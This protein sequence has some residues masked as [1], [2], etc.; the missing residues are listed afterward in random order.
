MS[1]FD[2]SLVQVLRSEGG[3]SNLPQDPGGATNKGIIQREYDAYRSRNNQPTQTVRAITDDEVKAIYR[4]SYW[5]LAKCDALPVGV[6]YVVFDGAVNS[7][8]S[9]S[10][11]WLQRAL[12]VNV[13]GQIGPATISAA[14]SFGDPSALIDA[15]CDRRMAFMKAL[16]TYKYFGKGWSSRVVSVRTT[17]KAWAAGAE[18]TATVA[19]V[20]QPGNA[21]ALIIDA[22]PVPTLGFADGSSGLG[23]GGGAVTGYIA[24]TKDQLTQFAGNHFIDQALLWLTVG[25]VA[26]VGGGAAYRWYGNRRKAARADALDLPTTPTVAA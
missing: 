5:D 13:D 18:A 9:Q 21:K 14:T 26:L 10:V 3:Y 16:K 15:I 6:S 8:V 4:A 25:S 23:V 11:K 7:G 12:G 19:S 1:E 2:R 20:E 24:S 22:K 17:G